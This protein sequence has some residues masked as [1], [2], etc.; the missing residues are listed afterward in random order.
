M[1]KIGRRRRAISRRRS[2][3]A[4]HDPEVGR[5]RGALALARLV[6]GRAQDRRRVDRGQHERCKVRVQRPPSLARHTERRAEQGLGGGG[7][8]DDQRLRSDRPQ[9]LVEPRAAGLDLEA[10]GSLV[11]P[12]SSAFLELEVLDHVRHVGVAAID[13][14]LVERTRQL[15]A[16]GTDERPSLPVLLVAGLLAD[17]HQSRALRALAEDGLAG[18]SPEVTAAAVGGGLPQA[19]ERPPLGQERGSVVRLRLDHW[20]HLECQAW[21]TRASATGCS[22]PQGRDARQRPPRWRALS[23]A[24]YSW[25]SASASSPRTAPRSRRSATTAF[26]GRTPSS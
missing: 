23:R 26:R 6:V 25:P 18:V 10:L 8:Q 24:P 14:D 3:L 1:T 15:A 2:Q 13:A 11:Q 16:G 19:L 4:S 20:P 22:P 9:L 17:E 7:A 5:E 12:P 21:P